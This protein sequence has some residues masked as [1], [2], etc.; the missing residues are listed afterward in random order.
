MSVNIMAI[1]L[2]SFTHLTGKAFA[3]EEG[4]NDTP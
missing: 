4:Y 1:L 2:Q 3:R